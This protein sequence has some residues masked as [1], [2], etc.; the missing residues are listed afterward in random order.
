MSVF[1]LV[2]RKEQ[3]RLR[4]HS[5]SRTKVSPFLTFVNKRAVQN[6]VSIFLMSITKKEIENLA[7]LSRI[8][9]S[10]EE[11]ERMRGEF[12]SILEYVASIQ[13]ISSATSEKS[14]SIV[15]AVNVM[16]EDK[17]PHESGLYTEMLIGAAPKR[18]GNYVRVKKIL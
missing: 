7:A 10:E 6:Y 12:D 1:V 2:Y 4:C 9:L 8:E 11:K 13:K 3:K 5:C 17:N 14:R 18:E 15:A 16:R